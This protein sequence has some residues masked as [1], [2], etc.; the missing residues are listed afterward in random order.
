MVGLLA[1]WSAPQSSAHRE[2]LESL[3]PGSRPAPH[4]ERRAGLDR[5]RHFLHAVEPAS[6]PWEKTTTL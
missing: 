1:K 5:R 2:G 4:P 6:P 3:P